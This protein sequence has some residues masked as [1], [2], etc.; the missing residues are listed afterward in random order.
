MSRDEHQQPAV[1]DDDPDGPSQHA[2]RPLSGRAV[3]IT[4][5]AGLVLGWLTHPVAERLLGTAPH[6][7][8]LQVAVLAVAAAAMGAVA[9]QTWRQL[10]VHRM[11]IDPRLAVNRLVL[12]R[13]SAL[14]GAF[15]AGGY[16]GYAISWLGDA[17]EMAGERILRALLAA[18]AALVLMG[19]ALMLEHACRRREDDDSPVS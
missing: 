14:V 4:G 1:P 2:L 7:T 13:S 15:V 12:G 17:S 9:V 6:I 11:R 8:W 16:T 5:T 10:Q 18:A 3:S 19:A